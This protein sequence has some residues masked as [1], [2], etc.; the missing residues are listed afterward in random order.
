[1]TDPRFDFNF[2]ECQDEVNDWMLII[3][4]FDEGDGLESKQGIYD[5]L[6]YNYKYI[7]EKLESLDFDETEL[8]IEQNDTVEFCASALL[9][10][11]RD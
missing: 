3:N 11:P 1:M 7:F 9:N 5:M 4:R 8:Y 10:W 6:M 2:D